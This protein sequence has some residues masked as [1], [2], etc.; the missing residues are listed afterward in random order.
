MKRSGTSFSLVERRK[1]DTDS[2]HQIAPDIWWVGFLEPDSGE[3]HNPFL[4]VDNDEALLINPGSA[5]D[6]LRRLIEQKIASIISPSKINHI[7]LL[8]NDPE[9]CAS[10]AHFEKIADRNVRLYA[11]SN[12]AGEV[13]HYGCKNP[14]I[15]LDGGDGII[16]ASGRTID[17]YSTPHI[18]R[19][20]SGIIH[21]KKTGSIFCGCLFGEQT[22][23]WNLFAS[24]DAWQNLSKGKL[25]EGCSKKAFLEAL[26][27]VEKLSPERICP[28]KGPIIEEEIDQYLNAAREMGSN[29]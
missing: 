1:F 18:A 22:E 10:V 15:S 5:Q 27:K 25:S 19:A 9:R 28:H 4:I 8:H 23:E 3:A 14:I 13:R 26:N 21:D 11:P 12:V 2:A 17:Y 20:G 24:T 6:S 16:F 7:V 29:N